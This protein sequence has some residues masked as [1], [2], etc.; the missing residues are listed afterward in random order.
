MYKYILTSLAFYYSVLF[1]MTF[2]TVYY[3]YSN[4]KQNVS[5]S[6]ILGINYR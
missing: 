3:D 1:T 2:S 6:K 4:Q 5:P